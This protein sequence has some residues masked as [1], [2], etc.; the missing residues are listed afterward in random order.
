MP[1]GLGGSMGGRPV[2]K[3]DRVWPGLIA[4]NSVSAQDAIA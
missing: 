3:L 2:P 1:F 4:D